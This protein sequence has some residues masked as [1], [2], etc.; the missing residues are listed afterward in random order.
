MSNLIALLSLD[1]PSVPSMCGQEQELH[2]DKQTLD[3]AIK[4]YIAQMR[5]HLEEATR[6]AKLAEA[7]TEAGNFQRGVTVALG[8]EP[9]I[10]SVNTFLNAAS[11]INTLGRAMRG[12]E[13]S[14][15]ASSLEKAA[16]D[17]KTQA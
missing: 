15:A 8:I 4:A 14:V 10:C 1:F 2:M 12:S 6:T 16:R 9:L 17:G 7:H 11:M 5:A 3:T 13:S